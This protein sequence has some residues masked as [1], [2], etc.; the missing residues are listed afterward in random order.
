M[1][2]GDGVLS[3]YDICRRRLR[4][5]LLAII[6]SA[7]LIHAV[8][9]DAAGEVGADYI[10][11]YK[12]NAAWLAGSEPFDVVSEKEMIHLRDAGL[13]AWYEPDGEM[14]LLDSGSSIYYADDK[15]DLLCAQACPQA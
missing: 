2:R 9:D 5:L 11:K 6:I 14:T 13:L 4:P 3:K 7:A 1:N 8:P 15:W 12:E 10:V